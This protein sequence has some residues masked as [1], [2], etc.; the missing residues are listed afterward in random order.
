[1]RTIGFPGRY[2]QGPG[3]LSL[4]PQLLHEFGARHAVLLADAT[5]REALGADFDAALAAGM[6][7]DDGIGQPR[8]RRILIV[9]Q[10]HHAGAR[11]ACGLRVAQQVGA[12]A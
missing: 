6:Q 7:R 12:L 2:V 1:M 4:L 8:Q 9:D 5:V 10:H 3:A 11:I